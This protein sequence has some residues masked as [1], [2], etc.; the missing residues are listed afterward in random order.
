MQD[1]LQNTV[2]KVNTLT[3][4]PMQCAR[5]WIWRQIQPQF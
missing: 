1:N 4:M 3:S 2:T 5:T